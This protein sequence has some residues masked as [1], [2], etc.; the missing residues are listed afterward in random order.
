M[1]TGT[2]RLILCLALLPAALAAVQPAS[3]SQLVARDSTD[4]SLEVNDKGMALVTYEDKTGVHRLLAWAAVNEQ[5][6]FNLDYSGGW[7]VFRRKLW[8]S[9]NDACSRYDGPSLNWVVEACK[10]P[11][12]SYWALQSWQRSLPIFGGEPRTWIQKSWDLRLSH[13]TGDVPKL[14]VWQDWKYSLRLGNLFA[15]YTYRG[16]PVFGFR[17]T[18]Q[19]NPLDALGRNVYFD[20]YNSWYG[21]G[22]R[23]TNGLLTHNPSGVVC[24]AFAGPDFMPGNPLVN[25]GRGERYRATVAGPGVAPDAYWEGEALPAFDPANPEHVRHEDAMNALMASLGD[26]DPR[27]TEQ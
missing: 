27:C 3:A 15:R 7:G 22:W 18:R 19:G 8:K 11:D 23:R 13:W 12:G 5:L 24:E 26:S 6:E 17:A 16:A 21:S 20:S 4:A 2:A 25:H 14:E 1:K 10:A 9:F